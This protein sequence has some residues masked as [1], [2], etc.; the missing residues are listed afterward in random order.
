M[1]EKAKNIEATFDR[2]KKAEGETASA[3]STALS[4]SRLAFEK[5]NEKAHRAFKGALK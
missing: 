2:L 4:E 1:K 5:A 3:L